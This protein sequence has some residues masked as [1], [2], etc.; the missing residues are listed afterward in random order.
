MTGTAT[1]TPSRRG[2]DADGPGPLAGVRVVELGMLLAGPFTGRLLGDMGAEVIKVEP[3]GQPDP[4]NNTL[5]L[6]PVA[7]A[8]IPQDFVDGRTLPGGLAGETLAPG[9]G[10]A[11]EDPSQPQLQPG[12]DTIAQNYFFYKGH[13]NGIGLGAT[14]DFLV[15]QEQGKEPALSEVIKQP[16]VYPKSGYYPHKWS[17]SYDP[18]RQVHV[19]ALQDFQQATNVLVQ[20]VRRAPTR[21]APTRKNPDHVQVQGRG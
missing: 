5:E 20:R 19:F 18:S 16:Q 17:C 14:N 15:K 12:W 1:P 2:R 3:P 8:E 11:Y 21:G 10:T 6:M 13:M 4:P 7:L 9:I